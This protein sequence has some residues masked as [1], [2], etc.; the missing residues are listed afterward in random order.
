M[1][2]RG[3]RCSRDALDSIAGQHLRSRWQS[4][5]VQF[6]QAASV[7]WL[8][9]LVA[10]LVVLASL[11]LAKYEVRHFHITNSKAILES[12]S[13]LLGVDASWYQTIAAHGYHSLPRAA[14]RFFPLLP[15]LARGAFD[16]THLSV[17]T[18]VLVIVNIASFMTTVGI[19]LFVVAELGDVIVANRCVW[20]ISVAP[21]AF[22][23]VMGY[24]ESIFM[25]LSI[26]CFYHL[27]RKNWWWAALFG[28]LA[29]TARPLG[30]LLVIPALVETIRQGSNG[31]IRER[32]G[33]V[34]AILAPAAGMLAFLSWVQVEFGNFF[35][36]LKIQQ[37]SGH[38]GGIT[39]PVST[40][41]HSIAGLLGGNHIGTGLHLPWVLVS[42]AILVVSFRKLPL[43]YSLF[44]L[45]V[46][47]AALSG[48]NL[49]SFERYAFS[50]FPLVIAGSTLLRSHRVSVAILIG[51]GAGMLGYALLTFLGAY[52]P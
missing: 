27:R 1:V 3:D 48:S 44:S 6:V 2:I 46:L 35:L 4:R 16:V 21:P 40:L 15:L 19:Y 50:A 29:A 45:A 28:F 9:W 17:G 22:I 36:P 49:E 42:V 11:V 25:G 52:V 30:C 39:N 24:S 20:L 18:C 12:R 43:S 10:R 38:H 13:G 33:R 5:R 47:L 32:A 31:S 7:V 8:P 41:H 23:L 14:L 37:Q 34:V 51:C 26:L